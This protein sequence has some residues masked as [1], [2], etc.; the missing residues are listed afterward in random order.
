MNQISV[1][2]TNIISPL[3]FT[4]D[5]NF[6]RMLEG[7]SGVAAVNNSQVDD[8][9]IYASLFDDEVLNNNNIYN[10]LPSHLTKYEK[11]LICSIEDANLN[12]E[13]DF[14]NEETLF[15][16]STTKGNIA[17]LEQATITDELI[18]RMS[19]FHSGK[20]VTRHFNNPNEPVIISNACISG[21]VA[22]IYAER[23]L[24]NGKYKN[25]VVVGADLITKFVY[26]GFKSF[27]ALS[28]GKC[29]PFSV[30][31]DGINLGEAAATILLTSSP[32]STNKLNEL[33]VLGGAI[34]NDSNHISGPSRT[35]DELSHAIQQS[36]SR[37]KITTNEIGF[38]SAHGTATSFNDEMEAKAFHSSGLSKTPINSMKGYFGHTLGAAGVIESVV[39]MMSLLNEVVVPTM[40]FTSLGVSS[41][42]TICENKTK[43]KTNY[44]LKTASG[45]GGCNASIV[46]SKS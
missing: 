13:I 21:V 25:T 30:N 20:L 28:K 7:Y 42:V 6:T 45:F 27:Q 14:S 10:R 46:F 26:S 33:Q 15:I 1:C 3:G 16:F 8:E 34:S 29:K 22:L 17:L 4:S 9:I 39:S 5:E 32:K 37:S 44:C 35:G 19:L 24:Q 23:L 11:L 18:E 41:D 31:R 12:S 43:T 36:L 40:G 38:I 2:G